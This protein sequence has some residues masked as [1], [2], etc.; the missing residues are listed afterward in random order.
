M[1]Q[2]T[3][4]KAETLIAVVI[5]GTPAPIQNVVAR[6]DYKKGGLNNALD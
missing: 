1:L 4:I 3:K 2:I 5:G 6:T